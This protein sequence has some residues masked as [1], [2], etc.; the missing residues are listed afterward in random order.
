MTFTVEKLSGLPA[1]LLTL[2]AKYDIE[3][4]FPHSYAQVYDLLEN[5]TEPVYYITDMT[6][7]TFDLQ[8][9]MVAASKT[10]RDSKGT[11]RHPNVKAVML[12]SQD[13]AV[14]YG[15]QGLRTETFGNINAMAF[16]TVDEALAYIRAA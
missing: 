1:I 11:F 9:I 16:N 13:A 7:A 3:A 5:A 8:A 2:S 12:I 14:H 6:E 4:D 15:V 10:S